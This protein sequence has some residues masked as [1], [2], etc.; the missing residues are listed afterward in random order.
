M[1][2]FDE[3]VRSES[4]NSAGF[5][6]GAG[7]AGYTFY[8]TSPVL[9]NVIQ[10]TLGVVSRNKATGRLNR[11]ILPARHPLFPWMHATRI[12]TIRGVGLPEKLAANPTIEGN[13]SDLIFFAQYPNWECNVQFEHLN[14]A[15]LPDSAISTYDVEW[16]PEDGSA[17]VPTASK[18]A[19]EYQRFVSW[20]SV[21][22]AQVVT[23]TQGQTKFR[24]GGG[25]APHGFTYPGAPRVTLGSRTLRVTWHM[26]PEALVEHDNSPIEKY[27]GKINQRAFTLGKRTYPAGSMRYDAVQIQRAMPPV[28]E[29]SIQAGAT[30]FSLDRNVDVTFVFEVCKRPAETPPTPAHGNWIANHWNCRPW[31]RDGK[32]YYVTSVSGSDPDVDT[33]KWVPTYKSFL[34]EHLFTDP[35]I[36]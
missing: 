18:Y 28:P 32:F 34:V 15:I 30:A 33:T 13:S 16:F 35:A 2:D 14:Y 1:Q 3:K 9:A 31:W 20:E 27:L 21:P 12:G 17:T 29:W 26:V 22:S 10:S 19:T 36:L 7:A 4:P 25:G 5:G 23:A 6:R 24:K 11:N 8:Y